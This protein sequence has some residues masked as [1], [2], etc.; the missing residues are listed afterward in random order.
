[1]AEQDP[2]RATG[3]E[4]AY[5]AILALAIPAAAQWIAKAD[6]RLVLLALLLGIAMAFPAVASWRGWKR[7]HPGL[8]GSVSRTVVGLLVVAG[9]LVHKSQTEAIYG[10][11]APLV[12][13]STL[14]ANAPLP[15][16]RASADTIDSRDTKRL[17]NRMVE[18]A[19]RM[20]GWRR[21]IEYCREMNNSADVNARPDLAP[22]YA[23]VGED[24]TWL[25][26]MYDRKTAEAFA[27][28]AGEHF[29]AEP[30]DSWWQ[31][32]P[33]AQAKFNFL[34]DLR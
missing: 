4:A 3:A 9:L 22:I 14:R 19:R 31:V 8:A 28:I 5:A 30:M 33:Y 21:V 10:R 17:A 13:D 24:S 32:E 6:I 12:A 27:Q 16:P 34:S 7:D 1:M 2:T 26:R 11:F 15:A 25:A 23:R 20:R 29:R 18:V